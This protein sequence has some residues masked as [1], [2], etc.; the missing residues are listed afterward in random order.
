MS[1][2][3]MSSEWNFTVLKTWQYIIVKHSIQVAQ[4]YVAMQNVNLKKIRNE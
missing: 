2:K 4:L 1:K 3:A